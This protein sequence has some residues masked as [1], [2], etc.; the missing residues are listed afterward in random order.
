MTFLCLFS[1]SVR[2]QGEMACAQ[3]NPRCG[4]MSMMDEGELHLPYQRHLSEE[5]EIHFSWFVCVCEVCVRERASLCV[6]WYLC[7]RESAFS[8]LAHI[9]AE[10]RVQHAGLQPL[11]VDVPENGMPFHLCPTPTLTT[12]TLLGVLCQQLQ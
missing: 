5:V 7:V 10:G 1:D 4:L 11:E 2:D 3:V 12:Q 9:G 6:C 8:G